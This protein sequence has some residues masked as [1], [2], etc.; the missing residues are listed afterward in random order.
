M[1]LEAM[2]QKLVNHAHYMSRALQPG[3]KTLEHDRD[4]RIKH[5][6]GDVLWVHI[7]FNSEAM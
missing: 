4:F 7:P 1:F 5:Y 2:N 6:A 3:D